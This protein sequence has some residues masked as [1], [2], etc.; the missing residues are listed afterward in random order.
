MLLPLRRTL[1]ALACAALAAGPALAQGG[2]PD[3]VSYV[4]KG[5]PTQVSGTLVT[6]TLDEVVIDVSG[7]E[8]TIP[9]DRVLRV[10]LN[11][12]PDSFR[13]AELLQTSGDAENAAAL[14]ASVAG[15]DGENDV[16][17]GY[18]RL[19]EAQAL[20]AAGADD[21]GAFQR[22]SEA[23]ARLPQDL[24]N[25]RAVP[26]SRL[27][28]GRAMRMAG[29][30]AGAAA[31]LGA[32]YAEASAGE[33]PAGYGL[34]LVFAA[35]LESAQALLAAG[36]ITGG[37]DLLTALE[38]EIP[39]RLA[40]LEAGDP[41]ASRL[42]ELGELARLGEGWALLADD[43]A[44][45]ARSFFQSLLDGAS[46]DQGVL[47]TGARLGLADALAAG[48]E[49]RRAQIEYAR[50]TASAPH[51]D[52]L[53]ARATVGLA[54]ATL[55]LADPGAEATAQTLAESVIA[56]YGHTTALTDAR[57]ILDEL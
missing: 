21:P 7:A 26:E 55:S 50:T 49:H 18:A 53:V 57:A 15:D 47:R 19:R 31:S 6:A 28:A 46:P 17:R 51:A 13:E 34:D 24:A 37:K 23:A 56:R 5:E 12:V 38:R 20:F 54:R 41:Q 40:G 27:L 43:K 36:D 1:A 29:D 39:K 10:T 8:R 2:R 52:E 16:V 48:G 42:A 3:Q 44:T 9:G 32:L 22:A 33:P 30:A 25:H 11:R 4:S 35:G 45:P 14:F